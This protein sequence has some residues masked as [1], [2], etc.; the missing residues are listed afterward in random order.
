MSFARKAFRGSLWF[1]AFQFSTQLLSWL[2]TILIARIL[3]PEDYGLVAMATLLTGYVEIV[4]EMGIGSAIIQRPTVTD[5]ELNGVFLLGI[6]T[7]VV[8]FGF[9]FILAYLTAGLFH[10]PKIIPLTQLVSVQF[11]LG[12]LLVVP[13]SLLMRQVRFKEIGLIHLWAVSLGSVT[14][15]GFAW[16]GY[17]VWSLVIGYMTQRVMMVILS[18]YYSGWRPGREFH[19]P[20]VRP[21]LHFGLK[22]TGSGSAYYLFQKADQFIVGRLFAAQLLGYYSMALQLASLPTEKLVALIRKTAYPVFAH[23]QDDPGKCQSIFLQSTQY[24]TLLVAPLLVGGAVFGKELILAL[25]GQKWA[26]VIPLFRVLCLAQLFMALA[27]LTS[28]VQAALGHPQRVLLFN[29]SLAALIPLSIFVAAQVGF[30]FVVIPWITLFPV[31]CVIW[32]RATLKTL[33]IELRAYLKQFV[34][35]LQACGVMLIGVLGVQALL[36]STFQIS[37]NFP[38][39]VAQEVMLGGL[40]YVGFLIVFDRPILIRLWE[41]RRS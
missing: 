3:L 11:I 14:T 38:L 28:M 2:V 32:I 27:A 34:I 39:L 35:P 10:E 40:L 30:E 36:P 21:Y 1:A 15:L 29:C 4:S 13:H 22:V 16:H 37:N 25:L 8:F 23:Y 33:G 26:P 12:G 9:G 18:Y 17:G 20:A 31:A 41:L 6:G 24:M 19:W 7:G 5:T